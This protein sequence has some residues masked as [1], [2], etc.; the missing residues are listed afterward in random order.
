[1]VVSDV[2]SRR[3]KILGIVVDSYVNTATP[4]GSMSV[5]KKFR[6]RIS[7][8]TIRNIMSEL[9]ETG[10]ITQPHTSAGRV[11]T[12]KGYRY[13]VDSLMEER[14][15]TQ[16]EREFIEGVLSQD[17][18]ELGDIVKRAA[19]LI[20]TL[21]RQA[22][23][24]SFPRAKRRT[25]KRIEFIPATR[26]K[27]YALL[28]TAQ[29]IVKHSIFELHEICDESEL[30]KISRFLNDELSGLQL[31]EIGDYLFR[32][33][34]GENDA[35]HHL[36]KEAIDILKVSHILEEEAEK[37]FLDGAHYIIEQPE[38]RYADKVR[39]LLK[40]FEEEEEILNILDR[41]LNEAGVSVHIGAENSYEDI[42]ECSLVISNYRVGEQNIGSIGVIGPTRMDYSKSVKVVGYISGVFSRLLTRLSE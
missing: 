38:F 7:P 21:T 39:A 19:K 41:G 13:Y 8:A 24:V 26:T 22:S 11:P 9:E 12:D 28:F 29:G 30:V 15:L 14:H 37:I 6:E 4:V 18:E 23:L 34:L 40:A 1:M 27:I 3:N 25:F 36:F 2:A 16:D 17:F 35:F 31:S 5:S 10:Y 20:S 33:V 32:K 42:R